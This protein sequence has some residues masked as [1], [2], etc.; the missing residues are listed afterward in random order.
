MLPKVLR[1]SVMEICLVHLIHVF[2]SRQV[3]FRTDVMQGFVLEAFHQHRSIRQAS[4]ENSIVTKG[5]V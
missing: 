3:I 4:P 1:S 5:V 2:Q